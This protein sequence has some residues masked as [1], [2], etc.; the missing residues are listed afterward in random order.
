MNYVFNLNCTLQLL[1]YFFKSQLQLLVFFYRHIHSCGT[2]M[3][4]VPG[5]AGQA[6]LAGPSLEIANVGK[7]ASFAVITT[8]CFWCPQ[9]PPAP[10]VAV[11]QEAD[12]VALEPGRRTL[13]QHS[14]SSS[15][16]AAAASSGRAS[17]SCGST[18]SLVAV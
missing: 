2:L 18:A 6:P 11:E 5:V 3:V 1:N 17:S 16:A 9:T 8:T 13:G 15:V 12:G 4:A 7:Q 14:T 10:V